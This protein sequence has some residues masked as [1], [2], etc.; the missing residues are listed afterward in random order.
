MELPLLRDLFGKICH[1][2]QPSDGGGGGGSGGGGG[3]G[4]SVKPIYAFHS[5]TGLF[6][7]HHAKESWENPGLRGIGNLYILI[8]IHQMREKL[9]LVYYRQVT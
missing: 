6:I 9:P 4:R 1:L 7:V 8:D 5:I 2:R 3:G